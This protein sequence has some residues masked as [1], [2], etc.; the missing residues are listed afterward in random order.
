MLPPLTPAQAEHAAAVFGVVRAT[1]EAHGGWLPFD[2]YLRLALYAPG[3]G[4][5]SAGSAKFGPE[6]DFVT[7]PEVSGL[8]ARALAEQC[9]G[10]LAAIGGDVLELGAGTRRLAARQR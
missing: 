5:Y 3:L 1:I 8:F 2:Q 10:V 6:G 4:Y 9:T 7:A